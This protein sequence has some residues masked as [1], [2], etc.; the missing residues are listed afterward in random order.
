MKRNDLTEEEIKI[1]KEEDALFATMSAPPSAGHGVS[2]LLGKGEIAA[3]TED[4][5]GEEQVDDEG[6]QQSNPQSEKKQ[7]R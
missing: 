3:S 5:G 2:H 6:E 4:P 1:R 7:R